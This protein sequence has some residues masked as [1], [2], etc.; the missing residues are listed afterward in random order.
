MTIGTAVPSEKELRTVPHYFIHSHSITSPMNA[1][2]FEE[3]AIDKAKQLFKE[4]EV[5]I[6]CGGTGLY[7]K[8][9]CEGIDH[10]PTVPEDLKREIEENYHN[11]GLQWLQK[12]L[13]NKDSQAYQH[14]EQGNP[15][16][17]MRALGVILSSGRSILSY[18]TG[19]IQNRPF[20]II[21]IGLTLPRE[22]L[23]E[24]IK[25][26]IDKMTEK[27]LLE[28]VK[29]L[30]PYRKLNALQ[31]TGYQEVF[32]YLDGKCSF[33]EA[34]EKIYIHTRQYAKRQMTWFR[35]DKNIKWFTPFETKE[36]IQYLEQQLNFG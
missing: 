27:G 30:Y 33:E 7:I 4:N 1:G 22:Q 10:I 15:Q 25:I 23:R 19:E 29:A 32:D 12:Q 3:Y 26:R 34:L 6:T 14:L 18:Q 16:R 8:A 35:K 31:T 2:L 21:K 13:Q 28:E 36:I 5:I 11:N 17:L 24:N 9:F 20:N